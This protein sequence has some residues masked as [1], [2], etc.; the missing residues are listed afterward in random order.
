MVEQSD[1]CRN[2]VYFS[3]SNLRIHNE[4]FTKQR[5][6]KLRDEN[7]MQNSSRVCHVFKSK[8]I[9]LVI[10]NYWGLTSNNLLHRNELFAG[11]T[12]Y[13]SITQKVAHVLHHQS[14]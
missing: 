10:V 9:Y 1:P 11:L 13:R 6:I 4:L 3:K 8:R 2:Q 7:G 14:L 5:I 12:P